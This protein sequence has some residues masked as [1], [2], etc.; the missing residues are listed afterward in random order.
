MIAGVVVLAVN[1][2][3]V[4]NWAVVLLAV[5]L[6]TFFAVAIGLLVGVISNNPTN[7]GLWGFLALLLL[8]AMTVAYFYVNPAWPEFVRGVLTWLPGSLMIQLVR[9][10]L[11]GSVPM[12]QL[13]ISSLALVGMAG[14]LLA[15]A[16][17]L[18][19]RTVN[20]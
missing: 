17:L 14:T 2:Y 7:V 10:S 18:I 9:Y 16:G 6:I 4:V 19:P 20:R 5:L 15:A 8:V 3:L 11:A 13:W 1:Y 12:D